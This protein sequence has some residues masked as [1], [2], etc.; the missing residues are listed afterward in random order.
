MKEVPVGVRGSAEAVVTEAVTAAAMGSG[1]LPVYATPAMAALMERTAAESLRPYLEEGET[2]VGIS[3]Q[4]RHTSATPVGLRVRAESEVTS[5]DG[6]QV[7]FAVRVRDEAG[8]VGECAHTRAVVQTARFLQ[9]CG[10]K[11]PPRT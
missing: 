3:L 6:R 2:S 11:L 4:L 10:G 8:P 7:S 9:K 1:D 5:A